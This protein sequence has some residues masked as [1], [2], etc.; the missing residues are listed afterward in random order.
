MRAALVCLLLV[1]STVSR[2]DE[3]PSLHAKRVRYAGIGVLT[4]GVIASIV[5][6]VLVAEAKSWEI[7]NG[8]GEHYDPTPSWVPVYESAGWGL[9]AGSQVAIVSGIVMIARF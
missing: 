5:S 8:L 3:G 2:A 9:L 4:V 6:Q 7:G 1:A